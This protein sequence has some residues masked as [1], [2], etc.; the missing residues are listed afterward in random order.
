[1]KRIQ[2]ERPWEDYPEGTKFYA[3]EEGLVWVKTETGWGIWTNGAINSLS[4][5]PPNYGASGEC[6]ELPDM[7]QQRKVR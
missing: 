4:S 1:M 2:R 7:S 5:C 3:E 6:I